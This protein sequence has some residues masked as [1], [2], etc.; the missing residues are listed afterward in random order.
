VRSSGA[1]Q[2]QLNYNDM[3]LFFFLEPNGMD[4]INVFFSLLLT[5]GAYFCNKCENYNCHD[6]HDDSLILNGISTSYVL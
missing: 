1:F 6:F 5:F 2:K 4:L 3:D